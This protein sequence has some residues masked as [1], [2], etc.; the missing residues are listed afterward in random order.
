MTVFYHV[1]HIMND[2]IRR[3]FNTAQR[4]IQYAR[5]NPVDNELAA[6]F[7]AQLQSQAARIQ[8]TFRAQR[9]GRAAMLSAA[10]HRQAIAEELRE[11]MRQLAKIARVLDPLEFPDLRAHMRTSNLKVYVELLA[12]ARCFIDAARPIQNVFIAYGAP[13]DFLPRMEA[14]IEALKLAGNRKYTGQGEWICSTA[15]LGAQTREAIRTLRK[16]QVILENLYRPNP[17]LLAG[18]KAATHIER[19]PKRNLTIS[20]PPPFPSAATALPSPI[21]QPDASPDGVAFASETLVSD[22][23]E[24]PPLANPS[25]ARASG[26]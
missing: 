19:G 8:E 7:L 12:R 3:R 10:Q 6:I 14:L 26:P 9:H 21:E 17:D 24:A 5:D 4:S 25:G 11:A 13:A 18:W 23:E 16:L 2:Q 20:E 15:D 22:G 1:H